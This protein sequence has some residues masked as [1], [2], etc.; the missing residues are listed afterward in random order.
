MATAVQERL[1]VVVRPV[2]DQ[3]A[4]RYS[5]QTPM[6]AAIKSLEPD[7]VLATGGL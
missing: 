3:E 6:G 5:M 1:G 4:Q 7:G 2:T